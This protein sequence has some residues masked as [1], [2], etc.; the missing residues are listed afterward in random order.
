MQSS[1]TF[2]KTQNCWRNDNVYI[3]QQIQ[4]ILQRFRKGEANDK[5]RKR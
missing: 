4:K 3:L 2:T 5:K 1:V